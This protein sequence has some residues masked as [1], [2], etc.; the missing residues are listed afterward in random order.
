[1]VELFMHSVRRALKP[2]EGLF[3]G[4]HLAL[5][6]VHDFDSSGAAG[7]AAIHVVK[8]ESDAAF[9]ELEEGIDLNL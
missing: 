9:L 5:V 1:M 6:I 3:R 4:H 2:P 8:A 7:R